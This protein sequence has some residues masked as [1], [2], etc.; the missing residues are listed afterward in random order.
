MIGSRLLVVYEKRDLTEL[1]NKSMSKEEAMQV[2]IGLRRL[3]MPH[4]FYSLLADALSSTNADKYSEE[5]EQWNHL[6]NAKLNS[7]RSR[8]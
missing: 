8:K 2:V 4:V 5:L 7:L 1:L 6:V 3:N